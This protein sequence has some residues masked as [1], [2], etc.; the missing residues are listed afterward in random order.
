MKELL[1]ATGNKGKVA[2][3]RQMLAGAPFVIRGLDDFPEM[4]GI[5]ETGNTFAENAILKARGYGI[6]TGSLA[7]AD[8]SG[9][10]IEALDGA[11]GVFS[12]RY[13]GQNTGYGEKMRQ[14]LAALEKSGDTERRARF[15]CAMALADESGKIL[16]TSEG[17][18]DGRIAPQPRGTGGFGYDPIF[19]PDGF[20]G[21]FGELENAIKQ[22][23]S[24]RKRAFI[25][26]MPFLLDFRGV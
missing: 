17:V 12:A 14:V 25:G 24:H 2:E 5:E 4:A 10:V 21:T 26:I 1:I 22:Q 3:I 19:V 16:H 11:P 8:D 6:A 9:L 15:V 7:L 13:G 23:I 18:C 20:S